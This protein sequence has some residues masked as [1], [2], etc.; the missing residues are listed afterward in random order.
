MLNKLILNK[1]MATGTCTKDLKTI[2]FDI[3]L[4]RLK[5]ERDLLNEPY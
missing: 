1:L 4:H 3:E 2:I 5:K